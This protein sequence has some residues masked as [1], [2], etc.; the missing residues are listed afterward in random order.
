MHTGLLDLQVLVNVQAPGEVQAH[1]GQIN[2]HGIEPHGLRLQSASR[3]LA[4]EHWLPAW[5]LCVNGFVA[6][7][8]HY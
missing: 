7:Q 4:V 8:T 2:F 5:Q 3:A 1:S 6:G